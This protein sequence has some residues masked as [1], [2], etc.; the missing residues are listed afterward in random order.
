MKKIILITSILLL[1]GCS[2]GMKSL[3]AT[4]LYNEAN[5]SKKASNEDEIELGFTEKECEYLKKHCRGWGGRYKK[6]QSKSDLKWD[7][8]TKQFKQENL[9]FHC[10]CLH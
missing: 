1:S 3:L 4:K 6:F 2:S 9:D 10:E 7:N 5:P 8:E